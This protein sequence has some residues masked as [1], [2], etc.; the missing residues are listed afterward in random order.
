MCLFYWLSSTQSAGRHDTTPLQP[1]FLT[2][3]TVMGSTSPSVPGQ[4]SCTL[5]VSCGQDSAFPVCLTGTS[6]FTHLHPHSKLL[7]ITGIHL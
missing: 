4:G 6:V 2:L 5:L 7:L 3:Y 1:L